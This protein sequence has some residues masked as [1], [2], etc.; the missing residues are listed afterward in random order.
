MK[1]SPQLDLVQARMRPG[2]ITLHGFLGNDHR[3]LAQI[4]EEDHNT[5]NELGITHRLVADR[6][7][8]FTEEGRKGLGTTVEVEDHFEVRVEEVRGVLPC[9]WPHKGLYPKLNVYLTNRDLDE[10]LMWTGLQ[11]HLIGEHGFYE[12][13]GSEFRIEPEDARRILEL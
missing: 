3:P 12:G 13:K 5:V 7:E 1:Q 2:A 10:E 11:V 9:P 4:L 8:F 6:M